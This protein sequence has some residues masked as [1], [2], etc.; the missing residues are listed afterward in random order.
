MK[1][2]KNV[3]L[4]LIVGFCL[5]LDGAVSPKHLSGNFF[6][7]P[8]Q[9][10][11]VSEVKSI[12]SETR[13]C[14]AVRLEME[15]GWHTY[16]KNPGD[17]GLPTGIEWTLPQGF[18]A[19]DIQW[20]FPQIFEWS[21]IIGFGYEGDV[22]LLTELKAPARL[23]SGTTVRISA[24]VDWLACRE[25]CVPGHSE[26]TVELPVKE[27]NPE[28]DPR[29]A[30]HFAN[31]RKNLPAVLDQWKID[32]DLDKNKILIQI[33]P[34]VLAGRKMKDIVFFPEQEGLVDYSGPQRL[35]KTDRG[36]FIEIQI[37]RTA[38]EIPPRLTGILYTPQGW[39]N[40]GELRAL[41]V[42][43]PLFNNR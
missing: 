32:A 5:S 42:D 34:P 24:S 7:I 41:R 26:L 33:L 40:S 29:W 9:A 2:N 10:R 27:K 23:E 19:G 36:Y 28:P 15:D 30:E 20:P 43:V 11:L 6:Q 25:E 38:A 18:I 13:F 1:R 12:K 22:F 8:V 37:S 35:Q 14:V 31:T 21:D 3:Y 16:W 17:S 39:D 4:L